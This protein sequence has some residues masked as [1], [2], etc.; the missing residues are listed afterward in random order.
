[1]TPKTTDIK[2]DTKTRLIEVGTEIMMRKGYTNTGLAEILASC[3]VP[4]GSF[5]YYFK[6]KEDFALQVIESFDR[7]YVF[8]LDRTLSDC[9]LPP[10]ERIKSK[11]AEGIEAAA[12]QKCAKGCLIAN[13]CQ[14]MADQNDQLRQRLAEIQIQRR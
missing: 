14:E 11:I 3:Q 10:L 8:V 9:S 6:S 4:K 7:H 2:D 1:M 5:Y 12:A 13:L